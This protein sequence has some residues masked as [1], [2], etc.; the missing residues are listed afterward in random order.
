LREA[1]YEVARDPQPFSALFGWELQS[2][3]KALFLC[4]SQCQ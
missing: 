1:G 3:L 4:V 2:A